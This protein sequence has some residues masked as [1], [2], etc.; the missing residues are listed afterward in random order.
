MTPRN[1]LRRCGGGFAGS[2]ANGVHSSAHVGRRIV[3]GATP[4]TTYGLLFKL[5][6]RP[7][8]VGSAAK[9]RIHSRWLSTT[10][11]CEP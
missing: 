5:M 10:T 11:R 3:G 2:T 6:T 8:T 7:T 4:M 1:S 9:R